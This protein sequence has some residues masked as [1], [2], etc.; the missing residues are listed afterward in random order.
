MIYHWNILACQKQITSPHLSLPS[1]C[2]FYTRL[3]PST[4]TSCQVIFY[5]NLNQDTLT[6]TMSSLNS[7]DWDYSAQ[8]MLYTSRKLESV[9]KFTIFYR[10]KSIWK[11]RSI[12]QNENQKHATTKR[13]CSLIK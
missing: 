11:L 4:R 8:T 13:A 12:T 6:S 9:T 7:K 5:H 3:S 1:S 10:R 2:F